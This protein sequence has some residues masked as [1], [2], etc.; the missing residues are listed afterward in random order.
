MSIENKMIKMEEDRLK[1]QRQTND[2][3]RDILSSLYDV[4]EN[5]SK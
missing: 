5:L 2:L 1:K 4:K 3:L